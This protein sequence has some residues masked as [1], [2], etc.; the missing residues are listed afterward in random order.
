MKKKILIIKD[1]NGEVGF[2]VLCEYCQVVQ[3][4]IGAD[5]LVLPMW[6]TGEAQI[7]DDKNEMELFIKT[8]REMMDCVESDLKKEN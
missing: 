5:I 1:P 6:Q 4:Q 8:Y 3:N 7:I 2:N